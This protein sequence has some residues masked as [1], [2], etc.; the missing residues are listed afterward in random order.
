[1]T[2]LFDFYSRHVNSHDIHTMV[3]THERRLVSM[4]VDAKLH[5]DNPK[6][7]C[8]IGMVSKKYFYEQFLVKSILSISRF[9]LF[10]FSNSL[11]E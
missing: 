5:V 1:M 7:K 9:D 8:S 3:V 2:L 10:F 4:G 6:L 11:K